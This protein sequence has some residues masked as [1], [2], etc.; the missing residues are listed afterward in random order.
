MRLHRL[1]LRAFGPFAG[2]E[3]VD[4][5]ALSTGGLFLLHGATGAGKT[6]VLD[7]VC[8]ALYGAV[9]GARQTSRGR[10]R[11]R[12]DHA[13]PTDPTE[14]V[15]E[16]TVGGRR[17]EITRRP[18]QS[19][20]KIRGGG[21]TVDKAQT[22]LR[23]HH[24]ATG[25]W[26][27]LSRS[28][29]EIGE[30]VRGLLGMSRDQFCQVVLLPQGD[31]ARF[32]RS[33]AEERAQL[34]GRLFDTTRF[35]AVERHL[36]DERALAQQ[37][38]R[39]ADDKLLALTHR[40][41]QAVAEEGGR[42]AAGPALSPPPEAAPGE[43]GLA[44]AVLE[45]AALAREHTAERAE[46][47]R[48]ARADAEAAGA[49]ARQELAELAET[50]RRQH[51]H[52]DAVARARR[53]ADAAEERERLRQALARCR[54]AEQVVPLLR[55][56]DTAATEHRAAEHAERAARAALPA[57]HRD[58]AGE[59][60]ITAEHQARTR[61]G[62]LAAARRAAE[63]ADHLTTELARLERQS[64]VDEAQLAEAE[65]WLADWP[66]L[67]EEL[68]CRVADS[69]E[70]A[71]D[72]TRLTA[73][74]DTARQRAH[75]AAE[76]DRLT[77]ELAA[78]ETELLRLREAAATTR[79]H[80]LDHR[81]RRLVGIAAEL[82][83]HLNPG[84]PCGV[85]GSLD[86]PA[87]AAESADHVGRADEDRT[88]AEHRAAEQRREAAQRDLDDL[89]RRQLSA[90]ERAGDGSL[91]ELRSQADRLTTE[92]AAAQY[93][94]DQA[95]PARQALERAERE[96]HARLAAQREA[97]DRVA[98]HTSRREALLG[99]RHALTAEFDGLSP[100]DGGGGGV[101]ERAEALARLADALAAAAVAGERA[102]AA[103]DRA[104]EADARLDD[105]LWRAGFHS[106]AEATAALLPE[107]RQ[108]ETQRRLDEWQGEERA[109]ATEF[110]DERLRA[111]A[112]LPPVDL[113]SA[114]ARA[115]LAER[116]LRAADTAAAAAD[117]AHRALTH[118]SREA[119]AG[120]RAVAPLRRR[121]DR[122]SG[123]AALTAG[124]SSENS[125]RMR[126]ESYVLAARLEQVAAAASLRLHRMSAGRYTLVHSDELAAH[127][128]R[129]GLGLHVVDAWTGRERDTAT[130]S[131]GETFS[132]SL[133]L[134]L[135]LA[136]VVAEEAGGARL[137]TLFV[138]E[139]FGTLD[140]E[141]L[142]EVL[143]VLD[144]LRERDRSVGIVSHVPELRLRVPA[145]LEVVKH[146]HGSTLRHRV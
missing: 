88:L 1:T 125:R 142:E 39:S 75:A 131:G 90:A 98:A 83:A 53:L 86:H 63:R 82:A 24:A 118:L 146:R 138:D 71:A 124:T 137:D 34:L 121:A 102:R 49:A 139:G 27:A 8:Y 20:P 56:R 144:A 47:S 32:L 93:A 19:R 50:A 108:R 12:S 60:L 145:Q 64:E 2:T 9:P 52:A 11:L 110:A 94:A 18:E 65:Q 103:A 15:L 97:G 143:S 6:S 42:S 113:P 22:L 10:V 5:D 76:R 31:F 115:A 133:A 21:T 3:H 112:E 109:L 57:D 33:G 48:V 59:H 127:G 132:A 62:G 69:Q 16:L 95:G 130:L 40:M 96:Y 70:A 114:E 92:L 17:L 136:D 140:E 4:F 119:T 81:E 122:I 128:A 37:A 54:A 120:A 44:D 129:S 104:K 51:R 67:H 107:A 89:H 55:L 85:C 66:A 26:R 13:A 106:A 46:R 7:A 77:G 123:L 141:T 79:D 23:E 73:E 105:A 78:A 117:A 74:L 43:A 100:A 45:W 99:E 101:A 30:E 35:T 134:A 111:A 58:A 68:R 80:W 72:V 41:W 135:G 28:H 25:E 38:L 91:A 116:R 87:P 29:Q 61:L 14:V 84:E 36:S 126:L